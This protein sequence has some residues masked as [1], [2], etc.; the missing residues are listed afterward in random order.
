MLAVATAIML[1]S[2]IAHADSED[3]AFLR[4][5]REQGLT[6]QGGGQTMIKIGHMVCD[7]RRDGYSENAAI[8]MAK[9]NGN[10]FSDQDAKVLVTSAEAAYCPEYIQ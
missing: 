10:S 5:L 8:G 6:A 9:L 3:D 1:S 7:L 4:A 2:V